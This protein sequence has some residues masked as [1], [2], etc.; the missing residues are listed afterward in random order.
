MVLVFILRETTGD[1]NPEVMTW[2]NSL[3][4]L[5]P[6]TNASGQTD[7]DY[8]CDGM[9]KQ[10]LSSLSKLHKMKVI[11]H[12]TVR[13]YQDSEKTIPE[14]GQELEVQLFCWAVSPNLATGF[15]SQCH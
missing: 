3:A 11:S 15:A 4:V 2:D 1:N 9:T 14:I 10:V 12:K 5:L 13:K 6:F 8:F 7:Q